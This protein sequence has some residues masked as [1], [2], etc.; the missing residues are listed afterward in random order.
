LKTADRVLA[1]LRLFSI[2]RPDWTVDAAAQELGLSQS[3]AYEYFKSLVDSGL[4]VTSKPGRYVIGPAIIEYDRLTRTCDP[5]IA[6]A[7]PIL[8]ELV[9]SSRIPAVGLLCRLYRLKVMCVEQYTQTPID[10]AVSYERGRPMPLFRGSAS[11]II[12]AHMERRKLRRY[13][14]EFAV[15]VA[16]AGMGDSWRTFRTML[17]HIRAAETSVTKGELDPGRVG[18]S[19]PVFG[20]DGEILGSIGLVLSERDL[21]KRKGLLMQL[22]LK[23]ARAGGELSGALKESDGPQRMGRGA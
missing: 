7:E 16:E 15:E 11:K 14:S 23:V 22:Q 4:L 17:R 21:N 12:L 2:E 13:Y 20:P 6:N 5:L 9:R 18:V 1:L 10:F 19:A 8:K 3:T